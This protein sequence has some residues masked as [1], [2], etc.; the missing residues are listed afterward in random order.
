MTG[1]R[2]TGLPWLAPAGAAATIVAATVLVLGIGDTLGS[3]DDPAGRLLPL[4]AASP[5]TSETPTP[6][7]PR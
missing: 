5:R 2:G 3:R 1:R 4:Q 7:T 6:R